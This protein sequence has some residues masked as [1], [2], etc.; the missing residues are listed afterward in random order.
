MARQGPVQHGRLTV[1]I[2]GDGQTEQ[3][4]FNDLKETDR[5]K[6]LDIFPTL[7]RK[8]GNYQGVLERAEELVV[9]YD[10]VFA[11]ID[12]D[13]VIHDNQQAAYAKAKNAAVDK[14]VVVL[15]NNPC[16]EM[17]LLLHFVFTARLFDDCDDVSAKLEEHIEGYKKSERFIIAARLYSKYRDKIKDPAVSNARKLENNRADQDKLY[18][19]AEVFKFF[20]WYAEQMLKS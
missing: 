7:P 3:I 9:T 13:K 19:R 4:Y 20:E 10:K 8:I 6:N 15:E 18:P 17:W 1:A 5:P 16:F 12:M 11:L 2:V 14:G